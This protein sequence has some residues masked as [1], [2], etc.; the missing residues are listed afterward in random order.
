MDRGGAETWLMHVLRRID[1]DRYRMDFLV[2]T[3]QRCAYDDEIRTLG[4]RV[5]PCLHPSR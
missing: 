4:S 5:I 3:E 2:H 1:R